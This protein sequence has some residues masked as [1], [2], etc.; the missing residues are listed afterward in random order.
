MSRGKPVL[1]WRRVAMARQNRDIPEYGID[2]GSIYHSK[3]MAARR[4]RVK[5]EV[6]RGIRMIGF[7]GQ[8]T[9]AAGNSY[10]DIDRVDKGRSRRRAVDVRDYAR[11]L[12]EQVVSGSIGDFPRDCAAA[13][14]G[15]DRYPAGVCIRRTPFIQFETARILG[16]A[17]RY[18]GAI[19]GY[20]T[21]RVYSERLQVGGESPVIAYVPEIGADAV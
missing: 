4:H 2:L 13:S 5:N 1:G 16:E 14:G 18:V 21:A 3:W 17:S 15:G 7:V 9:G 12:V 10:T 11:E 8:T 6:S 19:P 20:P